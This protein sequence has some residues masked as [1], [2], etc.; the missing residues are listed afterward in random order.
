MRRKFGVDVHLPPDL[1][2]RDDFENLTALDAALDLRDEE[3]RD[4]RPHPAL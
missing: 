1:D 4:P 3:I 2:R